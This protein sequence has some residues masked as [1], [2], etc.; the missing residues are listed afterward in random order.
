MLLSEYYKIKEHDI[1]YIYNHVYYICERE[2]DINNIIVYSNEK[3]CFNLKFL[4]TFILNL[5]YNHNIEYITIIEDRNWHFLLK[6]F[7]I[8]ED[9][10][11][12]YNGHKT[13]IANI[14]ENINR[15][16]EFINK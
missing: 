15:I 5:Y 12:R 11:N 2:N 7:I 6:H 10:E 8:F 16:K 13:Y 1:V 3:G 4:F 14:V 9:I